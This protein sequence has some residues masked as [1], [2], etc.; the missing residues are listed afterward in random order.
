[1][2]AALNHEC[3]D[4]TLKPAKFG[5]PA[6]V[7]LLN[8]CHEHGIDAWVGGMFDTGVARWANVRL[9]THRG[10][11]LASDIGSSSR[12]WTSD[13]TTPVETSEGKALISHLAEVGLSGTPLL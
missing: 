7:R 8:E 9:A 6:C 12:Y 10:A 13:I 4:I 2:S 11:T 5:Y 3:T 1:M